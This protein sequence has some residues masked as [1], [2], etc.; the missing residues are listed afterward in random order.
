MNKKEEVGFHTIQKSNLVSNYVENWSYK[1]LSFDA[2]EKIVYIDCMCNDGIYKY[3]EKEEKGTPIKVVEKLYN[4]AIK[5]PNKKI[6]ILFNDI[7]K[8]NIEKLKYRIQNRIQSL[9]ENLVI[10][11]SIS[12]SSIFLVNSV[13]KVIKP[14]VNTLLFYDPYDVRIDW[15]AIN[16]YLNDWGEVIINHMIS[17]PIRGVK[18]AK[19]AIKKYENTYRNNINAIK[20]FSVD[21]FRK[22]I[23]KMINSEIRNNSKVY[24]SWT[25]FYNEKNVHV[26]DLVF[27]TKNK[28]GHILYK[29]LAF[30]IADG[31]TSMMTNNVNK[32]QIVLDIEG[33]SKDSYF[34]NYTLEGIAQYIIDKYRINRICISF[35]EIW[36]FLDEHPIFPS[37]G[38]KKE[39]KDY[40]KQI[41]Y[42]I[43][44]KNLYFNAYEKNN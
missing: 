42:K 2:C 33:Y 22:T 13:K 36:E 39:L 43:D 24:I 9:P 28:K 27:V 35:D 15:E 3:K 26:Y 40:F 30:K 19:D 20:Q 31:Q 8:D 11:Y 5:Y 12:D 21:D 37:E 44:R 38:I 14:N 18:K 7:K 4:A 10:E 41:G 6:L 25:P 1:L 17:D 16:P 34:I 23:L 29:K 32:N